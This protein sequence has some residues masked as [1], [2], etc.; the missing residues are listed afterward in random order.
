MVFGILVE[1]FLSFL[2]IF[3]RSEIIGLIVFLMLICLIFSILIISTH[4]L[5]QNI[6]LGEFHLGRNGWVFEIIH[7]V[8]EAHGADF[9]ADGCLHE[10]AAGL[11][12]PMCHSLPTR[13]VPR[14]PPRA[15][16][17]SELDQ[18]ATVARERLRGVGALALL[19]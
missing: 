1:K 3:Q 5:H 10:V 7:D 19:N 17:I 18:V 13:R 11:V 2:S 4:K 14:E 6:C 16:E 12:H 15:A 8:Q 9:A